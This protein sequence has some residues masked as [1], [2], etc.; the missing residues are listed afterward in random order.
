[1]NSRQVKPATIPNA[2]Y[3]LWYLY[4]LLEVWAESIH[5]DHIN[6]MDNI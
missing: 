2:F 3:I 1:M 6:E 4:N 5:S